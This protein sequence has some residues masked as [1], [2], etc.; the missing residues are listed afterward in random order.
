MCDTAVYYRGFDRL[1]RIGLPIKRVL[2]RLIDRCFFDLM[3][4]PELNVIR[5][6]LGLNAISW[7]RDPGWIHSPKRVVGLWPEWFGSVQPDWPPQTVL[8]GFVSYD[9]DPSI[10]QDRLRSFTGDA[11]QRYAIFNMASWVSRSREW[12][13]AAAQMARQLNLRVLV[14]STSPPNQPVN[15]G[16]LVTETGYVPLRQL[17]PGAKVV[18]HN[19][20]IGTAAH[21]FE[22]GV[23]QMVIPIAGDH[24]DNCARIVRLGAG[25]QLYRGKMSGR[26]L[27]D[28]MRLLLGSGSIREKCTAWKARCESSDI[29]LTR[30]CDWVEDS[31][32]DWQNSGT[33]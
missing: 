17:M 15:L 10:D 31:V 22:C 8:S 32:E 27:A 9:L 24:F 25:V 23:P 11:S 21:A 6:K 14:L 12:V 2:L 33:Q 26:R 30:V 1:Y 29:G 20:G 4:A 19:G 28:R 3:V 5:R 13:G 16:E 7:Y 18:I